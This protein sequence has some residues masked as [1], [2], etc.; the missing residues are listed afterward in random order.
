MSEREQFS[1]IVVNESPRWLQPLIFHFAGT[2]FFCAILSRVARPEV[3]FSWLR[4]G[5][6]TIACV[7]NLIR[8]S[9]R[10]QTVVVN[11]CVNGLVTFFVARTAKFSLRRSTM[12]LI[13]FSDRMRSIFR[14]YYIFTH[15]LHVYLLSCNFERTFIEI[16]NVLLE[17]RINV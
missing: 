1:A 9:Q 11:A 6:H 16:G 7:N 5:R 2:I 3:T 8:F 17:T 13:T 14:A 12:L 10:N 4:Q 15:N